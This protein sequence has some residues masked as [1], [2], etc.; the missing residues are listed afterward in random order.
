MKIDDKLVYLQ[1]Y[2][3]TQINL[4]KLY[5]LCGVEWISKHKA[6]VTA[7]EEYRSL[8][9]KTDRNLN[10]VY[11]CG[12]SGYGKTTFAKYLAKKNNMSMYIS[13]QGSHSM[14]E[15]NGQEALILDDF[16]GSDYTFNDL[17]KILDNHT[18][19][20]VDARYRNKD[21]SDV[22]MIII[23]NCNPI[24]SLYSKLKQD[25]EYFD[26]EQAEQ[27]YRRFKHR[28]ISIEGD[29]DNPKYV[30]RFIDEN[31]MV[32]DGKVLDIT[33][34]EIMDYLGIIK[35]VDQFDPLDCLNTKTGLSWDDYLTELYRDKDVF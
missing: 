17:L 22:K 25:S 1:Q 2:K 34:K 26:K 10:V 32:T 6:L 5:E 15:Y 14:D 24:N 20:P 12:K 13:G 33:T 23:T 30:L 9:P 35:E 19:S 7:A 11:V 3:D 21:L 29:K 4:I 27:L 31:G 18:N 16:R 28:F 8:H